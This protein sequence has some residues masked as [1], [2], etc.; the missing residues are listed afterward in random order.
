MVY[1]GDASVNRARSVPRYL[2]YGRR[3]MLERRQSLPMERFVKICRLEDH[4]QQAVTS[5]RSHQRRQNR[6]LRTRPERY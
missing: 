2:D 3:R 4:A 5:E 6:M 1:V